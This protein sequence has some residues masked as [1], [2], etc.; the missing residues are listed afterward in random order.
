VFQVGELEVGCCLVQLGQDFT[1]P[2]HWLTHHATL[3]FTRWDQIKPSR[4]G[5]GQIDETAGTLDS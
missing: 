3:R 2:T 5:P 4:H 1:R